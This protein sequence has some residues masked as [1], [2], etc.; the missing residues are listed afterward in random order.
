M[1]REAPRTE[2]RDDDCQRCRCRNPMP[3]AVPLIHL[4]K[5][6]AA[7]L[8]TKPHF[9]RQKARLLPPALL[10]VADKASF[11]AAKGV[12]FAACLSASCGQS[13]ISGGKGRD[14][15]RVRHAI[16]M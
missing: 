13:L 2:S 1:H 9:R 5:S 15:C 14:I 10:H 16:K 3:H 6:P 11:P 7:I 12:A 8:R 4:A